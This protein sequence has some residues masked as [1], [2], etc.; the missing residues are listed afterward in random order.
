MYFSAQAAQ[1]A[2]IPGNN[3]A[4]TCGPEITQ[5]RPETAQH[6][7]GLAQ[8]SERPQIEETETGG[9]SVMFLLPTSNETSGTELRAEHRLIFKEE[10]DEICEQKPGKV[11][12]CEG[13]ADDEVLCLA[14]SPGDA[15]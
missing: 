12:T 7:S 3:Y 8:R 14:S 10:C 15:P 2:P 11:P 13:S 4:A 6:N 9:R 5:D 1:A